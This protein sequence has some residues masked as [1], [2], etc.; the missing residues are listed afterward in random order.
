MMSEWISNLAF[1][2]KSERKPDVIQSN[3][4]NNAVKFILLYIYA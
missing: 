2:Y 3:I 4:V 1:T